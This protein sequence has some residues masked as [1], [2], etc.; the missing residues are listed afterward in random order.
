MSVTFDQLMLHLKQVIHLKLHTPKNWQTPMWIGNNLHEYLEN[1]H[2]HSPS[3]C[4]P[5]NESEEK[6]YINNE[7]IVFYNDYLFY[8][9]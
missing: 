6:L 4:K 2:E 5:L 1:L 9:E 8:R 3:V 7:K